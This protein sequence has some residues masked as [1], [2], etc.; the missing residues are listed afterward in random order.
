MK[1]LYL[2]LALAAL[3]TASQAK[4]LTFY[5]GDDNTAIANESTVYF[6]NVTIDSYDGGKDIVMNPHINIL[7]DVAANDIILIAECTSGQNI[8]LCAGGTCEMGK[9]ITKTGVTLEAG[10]KLDIQFEYM[11]M[12]VAPDAEIPTVESTITA[13]Y[14][15]DDDSMV[16]FTIIMGE[17][18]NGLAVIRTPK[19]LKSIS[20]AIE[21][22]LAEPATLTLVSTS[23][24]TVLNQNISG[25]GSISTGSLAP[26]IYVYTLGSEKGKIYIR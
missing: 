19:S 26:G 17:D 10:K 2:T 15:G 4:E 9:E 25:N 11:G 21:Y 14:E 22:T 1:K 12:G 3:A 7:S 24:R 13:M 6:D 18:V 16:T 5:L 20:G 23:G 8:Q